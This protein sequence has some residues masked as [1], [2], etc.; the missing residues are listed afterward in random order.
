MHGIHSVGI[1]GL[2][3]I[4]GSLARDLAKCGIRVH[5]FDND[6]ATLAAA[7]ESGVVH[8]AL[9]ADLENVAGLDA[10]ILAVPVTAALRILERSA[11]RLRR[12][13]LVT[14]VCSTKQTLQAA[15][16]SLGLDH[17]FIGGHPL[18]GDHRSGW[19]SS[20]NG[21]FHSATVYLCPGDSTPAPALERLEAL[22]R[23]TGAVPEIIDPAV[24]DH[25]LA[26]SSH[27]PQTVSTALGRVLARAGISPD[28]LGPGG[29]DMTRLARSSP[30]VWTPIALDN[31]DLLCHAIREVEAQLATVRAALAAHDHARVHAFFD[32]AS[33]R[34]E[35]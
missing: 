14:D 22:W 18:A 32:T 35:A 30:D 33:A 25:R 3:L 10:L 28:Q 12:M 16:A 24:H 26:F 34:P 5:A 21:L 23:L 31:A 7:L 2:G 19:A 27:L 13:P 6:D 15:A 11:D 4:G 17:S 29:R 1:V 9:D 8:T 20:C